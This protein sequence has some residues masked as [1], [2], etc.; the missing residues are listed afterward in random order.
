VAAVAVA[1]QSKTI[2]TD[3]GSRQARK[4]QAAIAPSFIAMFPP[5]RLEGA[6]YC[7]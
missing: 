6:G 7:G 5:A 3:Q 4:S 2:T 1:E